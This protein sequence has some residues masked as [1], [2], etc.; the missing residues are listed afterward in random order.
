LQ[1]T[2]MRHVQTS[3]PPCPMQDALDVGKKMHV[4]RVT[5]H[6]CAN[7]GCLGEACD[8]PRT[9]RVLRSK[10]PCTLLIATCSPQRRCVVISTAGWQAALHSQGTAFSP[11]TRATATAPS[12][13][14][15]FL[16]A[17]KAKRSWAAPLG[18]DSVWRGS[19]LVATVATLHMADIWWRGGR[20]TCLATASW[21]RFDCC[22]CV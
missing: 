14:E 2:R 8:D 19:R 10:A 21:A 5:G 12:Q 6:F 1:R 7:D 9:A 4:S 20:E 17:L 3:P 15:C 13:T 22:I 11:Q 18:R 16:H